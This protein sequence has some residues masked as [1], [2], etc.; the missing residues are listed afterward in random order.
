P[1]LR[2]RL[3]D[4]S[5]FVKVAAAETLGLFGGPPAQAAALAVL[6]ELAAAAEQE[7]FVAMAAL[8]AIEALG[9]VAAPL[10][11]FVRQLSPRVESPHRRFDEY[12]PRL[13]ANIATP[14]AS[15]PEDRKAGLI[16]E[17]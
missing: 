17:K 9:P 7:V 10:H 5:P 1:A 16:P 12:V 2:A 15:T 14:V 6:R 4:P 8:S 13:I 11:D 3:N